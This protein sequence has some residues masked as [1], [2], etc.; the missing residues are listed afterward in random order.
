MPRYKADVK[1]TGYGHAV[2]EQVTSVDVIVGYQNC[3]W[4]DITIGFDSTVQVGSREGEETRAAVSSVS[5]AAG[6]TRC[7]AWYETRPALVIAHRG[8][9]TR[10]GTGRMASPVNR[11]VT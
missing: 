6:G 10:A 5:W 9:S 1:G 7:R 11:Q 4:D 3:T 8:A 2:Q